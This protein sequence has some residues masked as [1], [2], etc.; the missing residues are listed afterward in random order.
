MMARAKRKII[1][2]VRREPSLAQLLADPT[3]Q[4]L[5]ASDG[6]D[7]GALDELIKKARRRI[8]RTGD[9]ARGKPTRRVDR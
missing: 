2:H 5:M 6:V 1:E 3:I 9:R 4:R 8:N 7:R